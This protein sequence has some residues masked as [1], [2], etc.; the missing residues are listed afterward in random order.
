MKTTAFAF[1]H[2]TRNS[3]NSQADRRLEVL[4]DNSVRMIMRANSAIA[5]WWCPVNNFIYQQKVTSRGD[6]PTPKDFDGD[7]KVDVAVWR[8]SSGDWYI[9]QSKYVGQANEVRQAHWGTSGDIPVPAF[10]RR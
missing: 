6:M 4:E 5:L 8:P 10:Y 3:D 1:L 2:V 7:G 9:R